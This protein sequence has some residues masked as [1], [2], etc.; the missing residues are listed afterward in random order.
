MNPAVIDLSH[1]N[2][3]PDWVTLKTNGTIGVIH[4][5]TEGTTYLDDQLFSR[6]ADAMAAGLCWSTYHFL[7]HGSAALQMAFYLNTIQPRQGERVCID[8]EDADCTLDDLHKAVQYVF[9]VRPDLQVTVYSGHLIKEQLDEE[10]DPLL[11]KTA[12]WIAQYT[13]AASPS[14]PQTTWPQWSLWQYTDKAQVVGVSA[15]VDGNR[16]NG[17]IGNLIRWFGPT[18]QVVSE[19][20]RQV[21]VA[22]S[23]PPDVEVLVTINGDAV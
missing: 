16:W 1:W 12:L 19:P 9:D 8:F 4:K 23:A 5:A 15:P 2:P 3:T 22:I 10:H 18:E 17:S 20:K 11:A 6:A 7:K 21:H 14:W 13:K